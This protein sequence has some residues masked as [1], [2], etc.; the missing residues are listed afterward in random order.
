VGGKAL[1]ATQHQDCNLWH[2]RLGHPS[3]GSLFQLSTNFGFKLNTNFDECCDICH[4]AKQTRNPFAINSN[5][6]ERLLL[7][8]HC[9]LWGPHRTH[10]L[11]G[12]CYFLCIIDDFSHGVWLYLL[13]DKTETY[14]K[15]VTFCS[16][17]Q[18]QF[19]TT[20]QRMCSDNGTEF[21]KRHLRVYLS[22]AGIVHESTC[23]D[24]P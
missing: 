6:A 16:L 5:C 8:I 12:W 24:S 19:S 21:T 9:D 2:Q 13:K 18:N 22:K 23:V 20:I 4:R 1:R 14:V 3:F 15:F 7:L 11:N 17:A 10:S